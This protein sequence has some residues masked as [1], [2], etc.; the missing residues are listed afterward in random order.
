MLLEQ[1]NFNYGV[2]LILIQLM[3][4][5]GFYMIDLSREHLNHLATKLLNFSLKYKIIILNFEGLAQ[6]GESSKVIVSE[7]C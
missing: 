7:C 6:L 5:F 1:S 3:I 4:L 2:S